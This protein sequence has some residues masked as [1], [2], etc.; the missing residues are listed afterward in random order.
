MK[1]NL[2]VLAIFCFSFM[3]LHAQ[4]EKKELKRIEKSLVK[5]QADTFCIH[6]SYVSTVLKDKGE[7]FGGLI[8]GNGGWE[9]YRLV[10]TGERNW[11]AGKQQT[12]SYVQIPFK[13]HWI[14]KYEVTNKEYRDY[15]EWVRSNEP[16]RLQTVLLDTQGWTKSVK[17]NEPLTNYY[18][19]HPAYDAY[20]VVN[21]S[22]KQAVEYLNWLSNQYNN[23]PKRKYKKVLFRLPTEVEW[24]NANLAGQS[25][26]RMEFINDKGLPTCNLRI[27]HQSSM[28]MLQEPDR[29][30]ML[31]SNK[32]IGTVR[33]EIAPDSV[34]QVKSDW[35]GA[36]D[37][38]VVTDAYWNLMPGNL[39]SG[40]IT[41]PVKS[42]EPNKFGLYNLA[43]NVAEFVDM[44]GIAKGGH[45]N[46]TGFYARS[47]ARETFDN[48]QSSSPTR[49][50]RYVMEVVEE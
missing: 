33:K 47:F 40:M 48:S 30:V 16:L 5:I 4:I 31:D 36:D 14:G 38:F 34:V 1:A 10:M 25:V 39:K 26:E 45:W 42:F 43:G 7:V 20:P 12:I 19:S 8:K 17:F 46:T 41:T 6:G 49:G 24:M 22:H 3:N 9:D 13:Q 2:L 32:A 23:S 29:I 44:E 21:V 18:H 37:R 50:F 27:M 35:V 11:Q 28:L 15:V